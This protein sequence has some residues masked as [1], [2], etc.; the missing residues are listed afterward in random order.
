MRFFRFSAALKKILIP[1]F[2]AF[3]AV[4]AASQVPGTYVEA[5]PLFDEPARTS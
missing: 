4:H 3:F 5:E 2:A 1:A